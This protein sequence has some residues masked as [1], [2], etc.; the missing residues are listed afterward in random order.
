MKDE[1]PLCHEEPDCE[2]CNRAFYLTVFEPEEIDE[3]SP[4]AML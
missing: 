2:S 4:E 3:F 1:C